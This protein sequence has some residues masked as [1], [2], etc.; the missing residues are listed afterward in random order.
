MEPKGKSKSKNVLRPE[1]TVRTCPSL[2][3]SAPL[4][5]SALSISF[6]AIGVTLLLQYRKQGV[7]PQLQGNCPS[8]FCF[9]SCH[10]F[11]VPQEE[12]LLSLD[13]SGGMCEGLGSLVPCHR[14]GDWQLRRLRKESIGL[15]G[16]DIPLMNPTSIH[17]LIVFP[18]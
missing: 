2:Q 6:L 3:I 15:Q 12:A 8:A 4:H 11:Q 9:F 5:A 10:Q 17:L 18:G 1:N 7:W 13:V 14:R 16:K